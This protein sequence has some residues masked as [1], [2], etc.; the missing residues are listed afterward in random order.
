MNGEEKW[1]EEIKDPVVFV[2]VYEVK[3]ITDKINDSGIFFLSNNN[4][5]Y[6]GVLLYSTKPVLK[7]NTWN[8]I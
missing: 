8:S 5:N 7:A 6:T 2:L 4:D 1:T 3:I